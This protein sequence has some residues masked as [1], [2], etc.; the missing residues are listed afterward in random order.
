M[1]SCRFLRAIVLPEQFSPLYYCRFLQKLKIFNMILQTFSTRLASV[2]TR[3]GLTQDDM[4]AR[5]GQEVSK[6]SYCDYEN[7]KTPPNAKLLVALA[8][9]G[10]DVAYLLT[11]KSVVPKLANDEAIL[12]QRYRLNGLQGRRVIL[13]GALAG[14]AGDSTAGVDVGFEGGEEAT[15][16][17]AVA[18]AARKLLDI[19]SVLP[20]LHRR[21]LMDNAELLLQICAAEER[22][23]A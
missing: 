3:L 22:R 17:E 2:R 10:I 1:L 4:V 12:L 8:M 16:T 14:A 15:G 11:G 21:L 9:M 18:D 20:G 13:G 7:G 6:R 23:A 5:I 19:Y